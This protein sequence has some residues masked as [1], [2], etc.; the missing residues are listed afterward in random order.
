MHVLCHYKSQES[1]RH[2][3]YDKLE[4]TR[5]MSQRQNRSML[6]KSFD[7]LEAF[8]DHCAEKSV[9]ATKL[10]LTQ[11]QDILQLVYAE[12]NSYGVV[13]TQSKYQM[14]NHEKFSVSNL[15]LWVSDEAKK[16]IQDY[17]N[18]CHEKDKIGRASCRERV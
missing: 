1:N 11:K 5:M 13:G 3:I 18:T 14:G 2:H 9:D 16:R 4:Y 12:F 15:I 7:Y 6:G 10:S 8:E 17:L